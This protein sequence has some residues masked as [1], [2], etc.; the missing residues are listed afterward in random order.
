MFNNWSKVKLPTT[1]R[2]IKFSYYGLATGIHCHLH[3]HNKH[4]LV[5]LKAV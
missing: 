1:V 3:V 2:N 4:T 5:K